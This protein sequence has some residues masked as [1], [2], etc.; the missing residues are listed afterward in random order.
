M[1]TQHFSRSEKAKKEEDG[2]KSRTYYSLDD[3]ITVSNQDSLE[4]S[5]ESR[6]KALQ[7][8]QL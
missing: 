3:S 5:R 6:Y 2:S 7:E 1:T 4:D 8:Y